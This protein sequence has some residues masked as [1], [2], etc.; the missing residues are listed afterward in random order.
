MDL[1]LLSLI[2]IDLSLMNLIG[3]A[4]LILIDFAGDDGFELSL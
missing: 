3:L 4:G 2:L 1:I